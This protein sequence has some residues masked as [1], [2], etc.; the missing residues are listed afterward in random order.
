MTPSNLA[1]YQLRR[2]SAGLRDISNGGKGR[3]GKGSKKLRCVAHTDHMNC[4]HRLVKKEENKGHPDCVSL[5]N[6]WASLECEQETWVKAARTS[7][8]FILGSGNSISGD[9]DF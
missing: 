1:Q 2:P 8:E 7:E 4:K 5:D 9:L 3:E 6:R